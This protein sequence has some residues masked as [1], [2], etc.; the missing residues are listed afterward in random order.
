MTSSNGNIFHVTGH[1]C[2]NLPVISEFPAHKPVA[3]SFDVLFHLHLNKRLSKQ[4][5]IVRLVIWRHR[6]HYNV[7]VMVKGSIQGPHDLPF[8]SGM[9][10][11]PVDSPHKRTSNEESAYVSWRH[12]EMSLYVQIS[13]PFNTKELLCYY[14]RQD[15]LTVSNW[16]SFTVFLG[17]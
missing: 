5:L 11:S 9:H 6:A 10:R 4:L 14:N 13:L 15:N 17:Q 7:N 3:Q 8:A 12:H 1:L 16:L 2:G